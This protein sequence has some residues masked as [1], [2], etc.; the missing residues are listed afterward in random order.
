MNDPDRCS[1]EVFGYGQVEALIEGIIML[2]TVNVQGIIFNLFRGCGDLVQ[3]LSTRCHLIFFIFFTVLFHI[4]MNE[5]K[6][7]H[8]SYFHIFRF[9]DLS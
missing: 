8:I 4:E 6:L 5:M 1:R 3:V 2:R 7:F 9:S